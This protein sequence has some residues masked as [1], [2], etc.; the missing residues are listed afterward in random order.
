MAGRRRTPAGCI[1]IWWQENGAPPGL[2]YALDYGRPYTCAVAQPLR[3][4]PGLRSPVA[5]V[6]ANDLTYQSAHFKIYF[7][8]GILLADGLWPARPLILKTN[9]E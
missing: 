4:A 1:F 8:F 6:R 5:R 3:F 2:P 9:S 7:I